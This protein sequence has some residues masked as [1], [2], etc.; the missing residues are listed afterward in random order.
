M[1][2]QVIFKVDK[3]LKHQAMKKARREGIAFSSVLKLATRAFV[4]GALDVGLVGIEKFNAATK[5]EVQR[6][7]K[8]IKNRK[9]ISPRFGTSREAIAYLDAA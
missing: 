8:D 3:T 2:S 7:L 4:E 5:K 9:N 1:T 6:V